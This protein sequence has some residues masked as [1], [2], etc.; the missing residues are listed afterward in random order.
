MRNFLIIALAAC[1]GGGLLSAGAN[2]V[3]PAPDFQFET[4]GG[5]VSSLKSLRG[6]PVV[7]LVAPSYRSGAFRKQV[8]YLEEIYRKFAAREVI[9]VAAFTEN[10]E[11]AKTDI[12]FIYPLDPLG[13]VAQLGLEKKFATI[14]IGEDGNIDL[15]T[16][17][18]KDER[19]I[20]A[21]ISNGYPVQKR[22]RR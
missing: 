20:A 4:A 9:F 16:S 21:V 10:T 11:R 12:P 2:V 22:Q 1:L 8:E 15:I 7:L 13:L 18:I 5:R 19:Y 17:K 6:Q 3:R 14:V